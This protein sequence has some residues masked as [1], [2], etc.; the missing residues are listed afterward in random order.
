MNLPINTI[1]CIGRNY[2]EHITEMNS[3]TPTEPIVFLK[4][5]GSIVTDNCIRL[6]NFSQNIHYETELVIQI[7]HDCDAITPEHAVSLIHAYAVGLDLTARD[8]QSECKN[9]GLPWTK[10]KSFKNATCLSKWI[11]AE[12]INPNQVIEFTLHLNNQLVQHGQSDLMIYNIPFLIH[13]L[14]NLYGLKRGDIIFTGTPAGVGK[15]SQG[16]V[17]ELNLMN[18][19]TQ[20][21]FEV[22]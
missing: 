5:L 6:P 21:R 14:A 18:G 22:V 17:L 9:K 13:Y 3:E 7:G 15:L 11:S 19:L 16:D 2:V 4:H 1:F 12:Q 10:A 8:V 20:A